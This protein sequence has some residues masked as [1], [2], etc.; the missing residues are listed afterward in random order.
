LIYSTVSK[1]V[2]PDT[3]SSFSPWIIKPDCKGRVLP[4]SEEEEEEEEDAE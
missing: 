2:L 1:F 4:F 3:M